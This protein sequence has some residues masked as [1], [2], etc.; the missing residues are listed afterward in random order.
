MS[1]FRVGLRYGVVAVIVAVVANLYFLLLEPGE[2]RPWILAAS[3]AFVPLLRATAYLFLGIL[4]ALRARPTRLD[5]EVPY[6]SLLIR[7][8][9]L[10]AAV[11]GVMAGL[12]VLLVTALQATLF[13]GELRS[14][15]GE[16]APRIA[17][18]VNEEREGLS[19]PP[20]PANVEEI[21]GTLQPPGLG[22]L[23]RLMGNAVVGT[24]L[25]GAAGALVGAL[26]GFSGSNRD[27]GQNASSPPEESPSGNGKSPGR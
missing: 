26:R 27:A 1:P 15:A 10:A 22:D 19:E 9:A 14:F 18:Y 24:I 2:T 6:R 12:T 5:P 23:G 8:A 21:E 4:A 11:V 16:A 13:A 20:P 25:L 3:G 7:D 17:A